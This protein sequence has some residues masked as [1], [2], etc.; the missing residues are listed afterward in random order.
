VIVQAFLRWVETA[1]AGDRARAANA[2]ARAFLR[3]AMG[4][5]ERGASLVAMTYLLDDPSPK[6]RLAL[7]R[8]LALSPDAPREILLALAEDQP[9]IACTVIAMSPALSDDD[10]VD[11]VARGH[12]FTRAIVAA[13]PGLSRCVAA[14]LAEIGDEAETALLLEN[15]MASISR[16]S[17]NRISERFGHI[18]RIRALLLTRSG[19]SGEARHVLVTQVA[20]ALAQSGLVQ[21]T[22]A[23]SRIDVMTREA[24]D[25]AAVTI[26]GS[27]Q[28]EEIPAL[29]EHLRQAGK[30]TPALLI[31]ALS[32]GKVDFFAAA[33]VSLVDLEE[34][35][36]RAILGSG[37]AHA[38]RALFDAAGIDRA[39]VP[40]FVEAVFL[41]RRAST[42]AIAETGHAA[43]L[44]IFA[45]QRHNN[46]AMGTLLEMVEQLHRGEMRRNARSYAS[47]MALVA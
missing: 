14:A 29:V 35:R 45:D 27:V 47:E 16:T 4:C 1:R 46:G 22:I 3:S 10:L 12:S 34:R 8:A 18:A 11:L 9:E 38:V 28:H 2:L 17:L 41:W 15:D 23:P 32:S 25:D 19:L 26:A 6:V 31:H 44:R 43:L 37:R 7:A 39:V 40:V 42:V 24:G 5:E 20:A 21:K 36:I 33:M 13:R 30:L